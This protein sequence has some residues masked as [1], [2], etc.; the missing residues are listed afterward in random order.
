MAVLKKKCSTMPACVWVPGEAGLWGGVRG[1]AVRAGSA[2]QSR[3]LWCRETPSLVLWA[4]TALSPFQS[5][6][7]K[8]CWGRSVGR[9]T[10]T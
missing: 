4:L 6:K 1:L 5:W 8:V 7:Q 10:P 2:L 3:V 9:A